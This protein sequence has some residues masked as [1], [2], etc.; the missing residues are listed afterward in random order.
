M[1]RLLVSLAVAV[2]LASQLSSSAPSPV[3]EQLVRT[4]AGAVIQAP[5]FGSITTY[6]SLLK[7]LDSTSP[8][9]V[10]PNAILSNRS[11]FLAHYSGNQISTPFRFDSLI[12]F[13]GIPSSAHQCELGWAFPDGWDIEVGGVGLLN[14]YT[15]D[16]EAEDDDS[17]ADSPQEVSLWGS[18]TLRSGGGG[19]VNSAVCSGTMSFR[20]EISRDSGR[21]GHVSFAQSNGPSHWGQP[22]AGWYLTYQV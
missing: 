15:V 16:R 3:S 18:T 2:S 4:P 7:Y 10:A 22:P 6:P 1:L 12:K 8:N 5:L 13:T 20:I 9:F 17:W 19:I 21:L 14:V 11:P